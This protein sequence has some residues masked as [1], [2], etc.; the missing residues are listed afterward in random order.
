MIAK[1][2]TDNDAKLTLISKTAE[3]PLALVMGM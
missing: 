2:Y 1:F 3:I